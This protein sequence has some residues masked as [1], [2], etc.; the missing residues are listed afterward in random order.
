MFCLLRDRGFRKSAGEPLN[1]GL[2][3][4]GQGDS[5]IRRSYHHGRLK[6]ALIEAARNLIEQK[7]PQG[8]SLTEAARM[9]GVTPAAPYRHFSDR[10]ALM[11]EVAR[12]GF[13]LFNERLRS[14]WGEGQPNAADAFSRMGRAYLDFA[15]EQPGYYRSMFTRTLGEDGGTAPDANDQPSASSQSFDLLGQA[16]R[17]VLQ[18]RGRDDVDACRLALT[19]WALSHGVATLMLGGYL[20]EEGRSDAYN[21]LEL[22]V[23]SMIDGA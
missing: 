1:G 15:R 4:D 6:E 17:A 8:F 13:E 21:L 23:K 12:R 11:G 9:V 10:E 22:G 14:A 5:A 3:D 16:A 20:P 2:A 7:G 19:V 18:N